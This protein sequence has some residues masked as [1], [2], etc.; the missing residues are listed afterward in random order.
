MIEA[1]TGDNRVRRLLDEMQL[2]YKIDGNGNFVVPFTVGEDRS[3]IVYI[4]SESRSVEGLEVCHV[5]SL[6]LRSDAALNA[7]L[8][9][10]LLVYNASV[11]LGAW[12]LVRHNQD[13]GCTAIF[14]VPIAADTTTKALR[15]VMHA[16]GRAADDVEEKLSN[17][18]T[19]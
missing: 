1:K 5:W 19:F 14:V 15:S 13:A 16:V 10:A 8:A 2:K 3:Q 17:E 11:D 9:N 7:D 18:D 6:G 12:Q 4:D